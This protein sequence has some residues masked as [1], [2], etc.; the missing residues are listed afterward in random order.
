M[1]EF[2]LGSLRWR[3]KYKIKREHHIGI[4]NIYEDIF[5]ISKH[6]IKTTNES[7]TYTLRKIYDDTT[8]KIIIT[9]HI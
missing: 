9:R 2:A 6:Y 8:V 1:C 5:Q 7:V 4:L 3:I